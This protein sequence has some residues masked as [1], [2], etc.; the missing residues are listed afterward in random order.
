[1]FVWDTLLFLLWIVGGVLA[2]LF[3]IAVL[4]VALFVAL[5]AYALK[6][7]D[8][9]EAEGYPDSRTD[10]DI[11]GDAALLAHPHAPR[12]RPKLVRPESEPMGL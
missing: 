5:V 2:V 11:V 6:I 3:L 10:P 12:S 7:N 8:A 4:A 1:M 9:H